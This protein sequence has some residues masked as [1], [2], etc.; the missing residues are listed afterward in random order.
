MLSA[1]L[2]RAALGL[3][4]LAIPAATA[5]PWTPGAPPNQPDQIRF[6]SAS[7][8]DAS[9]PAAAPAIYQQPD[10]KDPRDWPDR[11]LPW[12]EV[13][14]VATTDTHGW[15]LG[16]QRNEPSFSG[17][18]GDFYSFAHRLKEEARRRGVDL[19]LVDSGDRVD[20]NGLVD[21]DPAPVKGVTALDLFSSVPFDI[22]TT[23]NHELYKYPV[24]EYVGKTMRD[25]F[26]ER[27]VVSNVEL[28]G[29]D[30]VTRPFGNRARHFTTEQGRRVTAFGPLFNFKAHAPGTAVQAPSAMIKEPWFQEAIAHAPDFFLFVGHM[31]VAIEPDSEWQTVVDAV[32]RVHPRVPVVVFGGHHHVR[33]CA[34]YDEYSMGLAAGRYMETIG[35]MSMSGLN[36]T[37]GGRPPVFR[38]R[39]LDQNRNTYAYHAGKDFDT[40]HGSALT[41]RLSATA[42]RFNLTDVFGHAPQDYFLSRYPYTSRHSV[43]NLMT[44]EVLP[45]MVR[46]EDRERE[47]FMVLNSGSIRFDIFKGPFTRNDQWIILPFTNR[48]L[49]VPD[50]PRRLAAQLLPYL[51]LVGEHGLV[52]GATEL[53]GQQDSSPALQADWARAADAAR[54]EHLSRRAA[55]AAA[56][57][58]DATP[59][60]AGRTLGAR[61]RSQLSEGYV[62]LDPP[63]CGDGEERFGDDTPHRP[64][65]SSWQP[66]FVA[67]ELAPPPASSGVSGSEEEE[68][69]V[70]VVFLDFIQPDV[71]A[72][73]NVLSGTAR[74]GTMTEGEEDPF[75]SRQKKEKRR[76][77]EKDVEVYLEGITANTLM[78]AYA[79]RYWQKPASPA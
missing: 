60:A 52:R 21:A 43:L 47:M 4:S 59:A 7:A 58:A 54:L 26:G 44:R 2:H 29:K 24:A 71:L 45:R 14:F 77:T 20:G 37:A 65:R 15:L 1:D 79:R 66:I 34:R 46:R 33:Q 53:H 68:D 22:V 75:S 57:A 30:N 10:S 72:A 8:L 23:G 9:A 50:V 70:D 11:P 28:T 36:E 35:F 19:L 78:E 49:F 13:N 61:N 38:R 48:F 64:F 55:L 41:R 18:W 42:S 40:S 69:R 56:A 3:F 51:N 39:Y 32:R 16:H 31:S 12:G 27:W 17:D 63:G 6:G 73:L 25:K 5:L 67:T 74:E 76:W 62:T